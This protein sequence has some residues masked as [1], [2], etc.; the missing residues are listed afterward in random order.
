[1]CSY[2]ISFSTLYLKAFFLD[3]SFS[4]GIKNCSFFFPSYFPPHITFTLFFNEILKVL[5]WKSRNLGQ[6][7]IIKYA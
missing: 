3:Y 2:K 7:G 6:N 1:M 5:K 4:F